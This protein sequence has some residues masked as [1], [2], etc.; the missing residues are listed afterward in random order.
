MTRIQSAAKNSVR[1]SQL[2]PF[3]NESIADQL[4][5]AG[6]VSFGRRH[7]HHSHFFHLKNNSG[8]TA[9]STIINSANG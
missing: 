5:A 7:R 8:S 6:G 9:N 2:D 3:E 4:A 1:T